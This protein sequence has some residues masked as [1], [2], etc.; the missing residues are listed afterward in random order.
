MRARTIV[1]VAAAGLIN[2]CAT[3]PDVPDQLRPPA[4]HELI[5]QLS[6]TGV[7]I[8]DCAASPKG[9]YEWKFR[10]PEAS[11]KNASGE[12]VVAHY[13]GPTWRAPDGSTVVGEVLARAPSKEP[14]SIPQLLL[15]GKRGE[16][17]GLFSKVSRVQ[18]LDTV[19]G[20]APATGCA[21]ATDLGRV[22]PVPYTATYTFYQPRTGGY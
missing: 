7:Q 11:L 20:L 6:A 8:Y 5:S 4:G 9:G 13:A 1:F 16:G 18:R 17:E 2:A 19:G 22:A 15:A 12:V 3:Q 10:A 14:N 21:A